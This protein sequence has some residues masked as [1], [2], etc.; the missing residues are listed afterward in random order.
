MLLIALPSTS[1]SLHSKAIIQPDLH[2]HYT[3][4][5]HLSQQIGKDSLRTELFSLVLSQ[6][7]Q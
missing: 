3:K 1:G 7:G 5:H 4:C 2:Y 6:K